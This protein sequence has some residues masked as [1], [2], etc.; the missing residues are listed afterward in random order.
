VRRLGLDPELVDV[1]RR[2]LPA[3]PAARELACLAGA[4][5]VA[6]RRSMVNVEPWALVATLPP[7][8]A[9]PD[10]VRRATAETLIGL[11]SGARESLFITAPFIDEAGMTV[12]VESLVAATSRDVRVLLIAPGRSRFAAAA[13]DLLRAAVATRGDLGRLEVRSLDPEGPWAHLKV[14]V[15]DHTAAYIGS[16]NLTGPG[17]AG[18]NLELGVLVKGPDARVVDDILQMWME[19]PNPPPPPFIPT[20]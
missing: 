6:G 10:G 18:R 11:I 9:L 15:A 19:V 5:W 13:L 20:P 1:L 14:V 4:A 12:L 17:L 8:I 2:R 3:D 16:A 7:G